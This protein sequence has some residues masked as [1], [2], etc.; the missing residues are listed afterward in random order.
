VWDAQTCAPRGCLLGIFVRYVDRIAW[1][2]GPMPIKILPVHAHIGA[3]VSGLDL[4]RPVSPSDFAD[5]VAALDQYA[6]LVFHDQSINDDQQVDFARRFGPLDFSY[7]GVNRPE[8]KRRIERIEFSDISNIDERGELLRDDDPRASID[9]GNRLWHSDGSHKR[10]PTWITFLSAR[11]VPQEGGDTEFADMRAA[12]D[13]LPSEEQELCRDL[14][15]VHSFI[16]S[17]TKAGFTD[18]SLEE[19]A[20][21]PPVEQPLV[22]VHRH[23]KRH[24][25]YLSA[26]ASHVV[27]WAEETGRKLLES[28]TTFATRPELVFVQKW[29]QHDLVIWD[30][31]STMHRATPFASSRDR[32]VMHRLAVNELYPALSAPAST[33]RVSKP[34][35]SLLTKGGG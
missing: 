20:K 11:E 9:L 29:R 22:R 26:H 5:I 34:G 10:I 6:V 8:W 21:Y 18:F 25:L 19:R 31:T 24:S 23:S 3:E 1:L 2:E 30:N 35:N 7:A 15:T 33:I 13:T 16:C 14:R 17:R 27:G 28:L 12:W 4:S 32:R